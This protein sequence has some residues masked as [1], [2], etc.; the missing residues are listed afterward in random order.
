MFNIKLYRAAK[1]FEHLLDLNK[2]LGV[3]APSG[4]KV[5][6][7]PTLSVSVLFSKISK[8]VLRNTDKK[9]TRKLTFEPLLS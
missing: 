6:R 1:K 3:N 5:C 9:L 2:E 7:R 8:M 4:Y